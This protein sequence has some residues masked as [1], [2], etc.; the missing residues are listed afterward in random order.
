MENTFASHTYHIDSVTGIPHGMKLRPSGSLIHGA[1]RIIFNLD[2]DNAYNKLLHEIPIPKGYKYVTPFAFRAPIPGEIFISFDKL[3]PVALGQNEYMPE[4]DA[5]RIIIDKIDTSE[6]YIFKKCRPLPSDLVDSY[7]ILQLKPSWP[8][9]YGLFKKIDIQ[10][11]ELIE[12]LNKL[13]WKH[14]IGSYAN[15]IGIKAI[16]EYL[17]GDAQ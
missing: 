12:K 10:D 1:D 11:P 7:A 13:Y 6:I 5:R 17:F 4:A 9:M 14:D 3:E 2:I 15:P 8:G 16:L